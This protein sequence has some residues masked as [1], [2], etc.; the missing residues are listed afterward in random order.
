MLIYTP[1]SGLENMLDHHLVQHKY[2]AREQLRT[3]Q[4]EERFSNSSVPVFPSTPPQQAFAFNNCLHGVR[5]LNLTKFGNIYSRITNRVNFNSACATASGT[6]AVSMTLMALAGVGDNIVAS[7][8]VH[9]GTYHQFKVLAPQLGIECRFVASNEPEDFRALLEGKTKFIFVESISNPKYTVPDF[10]T[11]A[12]ITH[13]HGVPL[14]CDNTFGC[15][16]YYCRPIEHGA[17]IVV[18]SAR[19]W[20]GGHGTTLGGV[21]MDGGTFD[22]GQHA[23][24]FTQFHSDGA[25]EGSGEVSLWKTFG[26]R[27][28]AIRCQLEVLRDIG[29]TMSPQ[30]AQQPLIGPESL[31]VRCD[32]HT[33]NTEVL[34]AWLAQQPQVAWVRYLGDPDHPCH[35]NAS[36]YLRHGYGAVFSFGIKGGQK[37][38][39]RLCDEFQMIINTT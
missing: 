35:R 20:I 25:Q 10:E 18:Y 2:R 30:A 33:A 23:D 38:G 11:L 19:K 39:F 37:A 4:H 27:A 13:S 15:A 7:S 29:S 14:I 16:G 3:F 31:A 24:K 34:A 28:F 22:W 1:P 17:D 21:I 26:R 5:L 12:D 9:G 32:R 36:K 8:T 6:A